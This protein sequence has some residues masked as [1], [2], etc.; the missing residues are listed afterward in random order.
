[1]RSSAETRPAPRVNEL[2]PVVVSRPNQLGRR[3]VAQS[4]FD[5]VYGDIKR[6]VLAASAVDVHAIAIRSLEKDGVDFTR[7]DPVA[8]ELLISYRIKDIGDREKDEK[9]QSRK[10]SGR[11]PDVVA[12]VI[13]QAAF[14]LFPFKGRK[15]GEAQT[16]AAA[17]L[18]TAFGAKIKK[19]RIDHAMR[20]YRK[21]VRRSGQ[22][23]EPDAL[24]SILLP[25]AL[26]NI[27]DRLKAVK[28]VADAEKAAKKI[29]HNRY[30]EAAISA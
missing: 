14:E 25:D 11:P 24:N 17:F 16:M 7:M 27:V 4:V 10:G 13:C 30:V 28:E 2:A 3:E 22:G 18:A 15:K 12:L 23:T 9:P 29:S 1:M 20:R 5:R 6:E 19:E 26:A 21:L 8:A